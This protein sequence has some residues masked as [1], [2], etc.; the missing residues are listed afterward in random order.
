MSSIEEI[1][2]LIE[3]LQKLKGT[4]FDRLIGSNLKI[5]KDLELTLQKSDEHLITNETKNVAWYLADLNYKKERPLITDLLYNTIQKKI[6]QFGRSNEFSSLEIGPGNG[7]F[8]MD[9]R[10][11][12]S[13]YFVD[14]IPGYK[15]MIRKLFNHQH[16][17]Y[18]HFLETTAGNSDMSTLP[19]GSCNFVFS[20]DTFVFFTLS[21]IKQYLHEINRILIPGGFV[22]IQYADCHYDH[23]LNEAKRSYW[24]YN[25]KYNMSKMIKDEGYEVVEMHQFCPGANYAIFRKS[26]KQNPVAYKVSEL[27]LD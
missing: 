25:T 20:W 27:T 11:W 3:K 17:K 23:D 22:F 4:D 12:K 7:Q 15:K 21:H 8:S 19:Q 16:Y 2:L 14:I 24:Q 13:N 6:W 18:L 1:R 9:F 5:L 26:G 10:A